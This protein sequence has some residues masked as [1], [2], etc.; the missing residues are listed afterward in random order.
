MP[1]F[2][3]T[4]PE[5]YEGGFFEALPSFASIWG[6]LLGTAFSIYLFHEFVNPLRVRFR[7]YKKHYCYEPF[8][9][10]YFLNCFKRLNEQKVGLKHA[11]EN[12]F[13]LSKNKK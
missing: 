8:Q 1:E 2:Y 9:A 5:I 12:P 4:E 10:N 6:V 11:R 3:I 13:G 7:W